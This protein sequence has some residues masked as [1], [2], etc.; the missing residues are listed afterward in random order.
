ML[1]VGL[2]SRNSFFPVYFGEHFLGDVEGRVRSRHAAVNRALEQHFLNFVT[3]SERGV[4][5]G[6]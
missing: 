4:V 5:A 1:A 3:K 2:G 6:K